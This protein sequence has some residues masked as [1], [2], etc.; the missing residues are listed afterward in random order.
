MA[1]RTEQTLR[2]MWDESAKLANE[3]GKLWAT[4]DGS[5]TEAEVAERTAAAHRTAEKNSRDV[6]DAMA[7]EAADLSDLV[8]RERTEA[9]LAPLT[10]GEPYPVDVVPAEQ[11]MTD[12]TLVASQSSTVTETLTDGQLDASGATA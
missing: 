8:N 2:R 12:D 11:P 4:A 10:P 9:G 7:A 5:R 3:A 6:G 1:I